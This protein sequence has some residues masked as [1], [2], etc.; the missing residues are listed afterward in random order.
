MYTIPPNQRVG[1]QNSCREEKV[2]RKKE[3]AA[4]DATVKMAT[5]D[6]R[7]EPV[8]ALIKL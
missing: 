1:R 5:I 8:S 4:A 6:G 3:K 7:D 2:K